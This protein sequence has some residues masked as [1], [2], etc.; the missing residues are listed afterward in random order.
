MNQVIIVFP[1]GGYILLIILYVILFFIVTVLLSKD[2]DYDNIALMCSLF[3]TTDTSEFLYFL[4]KLI[5]DSV[6]YVPSKFKLKAKPE[7]YIYIFFF[8]LIVVPL[9]NGDYALL[10]QK[11]F[12]S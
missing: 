11:L 4:S 5:T 12:F 2:G 3:S 6:D 1:N 8:I 9:S 7:L 10:E